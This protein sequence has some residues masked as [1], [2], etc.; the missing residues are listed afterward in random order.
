MW[1]ALIAP[2]MGTI[3]SVLDKI[4]PDAA[5][6]DRL[7]F[8]IEKSFMD[9]QNNRLDAATKIILA[10]SQGNLLQRSW[11]PILML[12]FAGLVGAHW[13]GFTPEN[14]SEASILALLDIVQVGI[15]G[16][17]LGRSGEKMIKEYKK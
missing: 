2:I 15:G 7:K 9:N 1:Q 14:L 8:E 10:E 12:W 17:V 16:Y 3:D 11:R 5:E 4:V 6:R 13:L